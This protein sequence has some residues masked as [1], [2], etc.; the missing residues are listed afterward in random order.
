[1]Y[2]QFINSDPIMKKILTFNNGK[3]TVNTSDESLYLV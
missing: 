3:Y 2:R 1:M